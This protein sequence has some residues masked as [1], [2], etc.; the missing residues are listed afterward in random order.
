MGNKGKLKDEVSIQRDRM[1]STHSESGS[2][3]DTEIC[4]KDIISLL[5][6]GDD[7]PEIKS[8]KQVFSIASKVKSIR[9][10]YEKHLSEKK[11][12]RESRNNLKDVYNMK[13][14]KVEL[15]FEKIEVSLP[16]KKKKEKKKEKKKKKKKKP[17]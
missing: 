3:G 8:S 10:R 7:V 2:N 11:T 4:R 17:L 15:S 12:I 13:D 16:T 5:P 9:H 14:E 6:K 1:T